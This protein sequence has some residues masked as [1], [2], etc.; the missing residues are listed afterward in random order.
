MKDNSPFAS[1]K[2]ALTSAIQAG[3]ARD[4]AVFKANRRF[5]RTALGKI[6]YRPGD[7]GPSG[8]AT[9]IKKVYGRILSRRERKQHA[10][11][12]SQP[13]QKFYARG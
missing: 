12:N 2:D 13:F 6:P 10:K 1:K 5:K 8:I 9:E 7:R 4:Y 3:A 11:A